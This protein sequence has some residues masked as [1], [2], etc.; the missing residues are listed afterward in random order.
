VTLSPRLHVAVLLAACLSLP[1]ASAHA[2]EPFALQVPCNATAENSVGTVRPCITCHDNA[3]G[4]SGCDTPPCFNPFGTAFDANGRVWDATLAMMDSDGDGYTNG[5]E[6]GDPTGTWVIGEP[7]PPTCACATRPGA[8]TFTPGDTDADSDG[9]CCWGVDT[10]GDGDCLDTGEN[11][12]TSFDCDERDD[13]VYSGRAEL[14]ANAV[15]N[16]CDG[17]PTLLDDECADVV[18]RD[19]DGYCPMGID[20]NRDR[21]C[22]DAGEMTA[23]VDC[24]DDEVTVSP[25]A[26]E[27][28]IDGLDN[29]CDGDVDGDDAECTSETDADGDGYCPV[30]LDGNGDGDC[31]DAGEN[32]GVS[33][34]CDDSVA[35]VNPAATE[36]CTDFADNDCDGLADF[37]DEED[38]GAFFDADGDGYCPAGRDGNG[39]GN[40]TD[41]GETDD[42]GDCNDDDA[43]INPGMG[44]VCTNGGVDDDCDGAASL[45][46][47]DCAGYIDADGDTYCFVGGDMDGDGTCVDEGEQGGDGD[48][49]ETR[50]DINPSIP[51]DCTDGV[52]NDCNGSTDAADRV[53]CFDYRDHD[54]DGFCWVGH[55][56]NGDGDC[57][58]AGEQGE[59]REWRAAED[60]HSDEDAGGTGSELDPTRYPGAPEHCADN[61]DDDLDGMIDEA[62]YCRTDVDADGDGWCP[63]GRDDNGDGDCEDDGENAAE[64]D[65]D[66]ADA[67]VSP[68]QEERCLEPVDADCDDQ[69]GVADPDCFVLLDRDGDGVCGS[70]V[71]DNSDGDC[72]DDG[73]QRFGEDCDDRDPAVS[74]RAAESCGDGIDND[75][76]GDVDYDDRACSCEADAAC[77]D[78]DAC[79]LDTC[80]PDGT[81]DNVP[82]PR[83]GDGGMV[84]GGPGPDAADD[85]NCAAVGVGSGPGPS[86]AWLALALA[87]L[88]WRRRRREIP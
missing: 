44:E 24:D 43:S 46:D 37:R 29:D 65:C 75:C 45:A 76:N 8:A 32:D 21:D 7:S 64:Y 52:D 70:G 31:L 22:I 40:C 19:G 16:D 82:D 49:D 48:C 9:Y 58:D 11:D 68:G 78:G 20:D 47:D 73:E 38:C 23:D 86:L 50:T 87:G 2:F 56:D 60:P 34:D 55:D 26:R 41:A 36:V 10:T 59:P 6:L 27:F 74:S 15:D 77:D 63:V 84:D 81:C 18:D 85:C 61:V 69:V 1:A 28:C 13:T 67:D 51:E 71:D 62:G 30:G 35:E 25:A 12:G 80:T 17:L 42:P 33:F 66:D 54:L 4:G 88:L 79:T 39:N 14:C 57:A 53:V 3:D 83:C 72:L 5:E